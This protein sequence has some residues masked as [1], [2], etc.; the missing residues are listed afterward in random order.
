MISYPLFSEKALYVY[1]NSNDEQLESLLSVSLQDI[2]LESDE[3]EE[4]YEYKLLHL[5]EKKL[6]END[7]NG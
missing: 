6:K 7:K 5:I 2:W 3:S 1:R 4:H